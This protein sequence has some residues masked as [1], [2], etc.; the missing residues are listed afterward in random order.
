MT[1]ITWYESNQGQKLLVPGQSPALAG[2]CV[3]ACDIALNEIYGLPY[4]YANAAD[5]WNNPQELINHFDLISDG[6]VK[7]GDFVVYSGNLPGSEGY[8]HIDLAL[9]D[10][11]RSNYLGA[12]SNWGGNLTLHQVNHAGSENSYILGSLRFRSQ[13]MQPIRPDE[14]NN[15]VGLCWGVQTDP[16]APGYNAVDRGNDHKNLDGKPFYEAYNTVYFDGRTLDYRK[17]CNTALAAAPSG[18]APYSGPELYVKT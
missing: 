12:D 8:G 11:S 17:K 13:N 14:V 16:S 15:L 18:V 10:G 1:P 5:W 2:Q 6:S 9:Q 4:H 7:S 3:Q